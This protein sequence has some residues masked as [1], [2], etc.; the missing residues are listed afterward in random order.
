MGI[1]RL[2]VGVDGSTNAAAAVAWA[3]A[4][5]SQL[6]ASVVA[7][8]ALGLL[9]HPDRAAQVARLEGEWTAPLRE[10]GVECACIARDGN[11]ISVV[12]DVAAEHDVDLIV[13][14]SRGLG[15]FPERLLG[16]T[17]TQVAQRSTR[18]VVVVPDLSAPAAG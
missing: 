14:G 12:L 11:P 4:A 6:G 3:T 8:H 7:V 18:P 16:S 5:A 2:L 10:A 9:E 15:G 1:E 13:L 17:S